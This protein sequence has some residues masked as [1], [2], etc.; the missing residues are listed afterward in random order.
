L[1]HLGG[2]ASLS[3]SLLS[4]KRLWGLIACHHRMPCLIPFADRLALEVLGARISAEIAL[5]EQR[6]NTAQMVASQALHHDLANEAI[7]HGGTQAALR[8]RLSDLA[9][10]FRADGIAM[11]SPSEV[12]ATGNVP[13]GR[14]LA[15]LVE[16]LAGRDIRNCWATEALAEQ[17]EDAHELAPD[18]AGMIALRLDRRRDAFLLIFRPEV[19]RTVTWAGDPHHP[20]EE[21]EEGLGPRHSFHAWKETVKGRAQPWS[22]ADLRFA[23]DLLVTLR[24]LFGQEKRRG[25]APPRDDVEAMRQK[26]LNIISHELRTPLTA[27]EGYSEF[28]A[29]A[30]ADNPS[31]EPRHYLSEIRIGARRLESAI[32]RML[33]AARLEAG[34]LAMKRDA[35]DLRDLVQRAVAN[36]EA[37]AATKSIHIDFPAADPMPCMLD[38]ERIEGA[39]EQL[40]DN[41]LKFT[42]PGGRIGVHL[43]RRGG[44]V[45]FQVSDSG[46]GITPD[47]LP[48]V[49]EKFYQA[50]I[51]PTRAFGGLG[52]GLFIAKQVITAHGGQIGAVSEP[53]RG[54]TFWFTLPC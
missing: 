9:R 6:S 17:W 45:R 38:A 47:V 25:L 46:P 52:L 32:G 28:L 48:H 34:L 7:R 18:A 31:P 13:S 53:G 4:G 27:I 23:G 49:F 36:A 50:D 24:K 40:L 3:I 16:W 26:L 19:V 14:A 54:S 37:S 30:L 5:H 12:T 44:E 21:F 42:P 33:D 8:S 10:H 43:E 41:A 20:L 51:E 39:L 35:C 1:K 2:R 11:A 22:A 15:R 29:D